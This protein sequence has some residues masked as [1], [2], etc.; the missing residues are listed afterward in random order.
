LIIVIEEKRTLKFRLELIEG[1]LFYYNRR[2][3]YYAIGV[4]TA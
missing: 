3:I 1:L 2:I 4:Y